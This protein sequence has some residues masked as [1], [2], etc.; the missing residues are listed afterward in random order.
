MTYEI[1]TNRGMSDFIIY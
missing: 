1:V